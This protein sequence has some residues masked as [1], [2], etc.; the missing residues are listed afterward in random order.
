MKR[1][2]IVAWLVAGLALGAL[3]FWPA[4]S[5]ESRLL[6]ALPAK[7]EVQ[8][9]G[10]IWSGEGALR[11][12][13]RVWPLAWRIDAAS[14]LSARLGW[15]VKAQP[16]GASA[17][18]LVALGFA[19]TRVTDFTYEGEMQ[20][21]ASLLPALTLMGANGRARIG[22]PA[23][24]ISHRVPWHIEG[25]ANVELRELSVAAISAQVLGNAT[26]ALQ[27]AGDKVNFAI[28]KS[29]GVL[30]M[31]GKGSLDNAGG[32]VF[33]GSALPLS[34]FDADGRAHLARMATAQ[35]DGRYRFEVKTKW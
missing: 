17:N 9:A 3:A 33:Q 26:L 7:S 35:S 23:L 20:P 32:F 13:G 15:N 25:A 29:D 14:L 12:R 8:L 16:S 11:I 10:S 30:A 34:T 28:G 18:A 19:D 5:L 4:A 6:A 27:G 21:L 2:A 24:A 31:D 1:R 22:A